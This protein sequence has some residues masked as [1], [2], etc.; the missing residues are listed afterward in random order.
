MK[1][2]AIPLAVLLAVC[3][4]MT[5]AVAAGGS[6]SDP[7]AAL[8]YLTGT[9][10]SYIMGKVDSKLDASDAAIT[11]AAAGQGASS[12]S[13]AVQ[14]RLKSGDSAACSTGTEFCVLAGTVAASFS[15]GAVVDVTTGSELAGGGTLTPMHQYLVA[16]N[17]SASFAVSGSTAVVEY[18][19]KAAISYSSAPDMNAMAAALK[20]LGLFRGN[21]VGYGSGYSLET[22]PTRTEAL[23]MLIRLLGEEDKALACTDSHP[24]SDVA[25]WADRY[26]AYAY[27]KGYTNGVSRTKFGGSSTASAAMY[28]EFVMRALGYSDT[29][30]RDISTTLSNALADG[31]INKAEYARLTSGTFLRSEVVYLSYYALTTELKNGGGTLEQSLEAGGVFTAAQAKAAHA[32]VSTARLS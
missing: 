25:G 13:A 3:L 4:G 9:F 22:A 29:S 15:S 5:A 2:R 24:F 28:A 14:L 17:T 31:V 21:G 12:S 32:M 11:S 20:S 6:S 26:V 27:S 1:K 7:L 23:V 10:H 8:S 16:E 30:H 18:S 19:G